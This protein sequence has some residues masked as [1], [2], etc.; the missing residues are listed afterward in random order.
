MNELSTAWLGILTY[1]W[2]RPSKTCLGAA[3]VMVVIG[4]V[5]VVVVVVVGAF[6]V[7]VVLGD[8]D[9]GIHS[10]LH[11]KHFMRQTTQS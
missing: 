5:V 3:V 7:V 6:V 2:L 1:Q 8:Y 11:S 10:L 9:E 4:D